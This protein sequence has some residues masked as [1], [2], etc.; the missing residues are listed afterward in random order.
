[1]TPQGRHPSTDAITVAL[2]G[3][4]SVGGWLI[5]DGWGHPMLEVTVMSALI[6]TFLIVLAMWGLLLPALAE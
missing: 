1:M 5:W 6:G 4:A 3:L 2:G